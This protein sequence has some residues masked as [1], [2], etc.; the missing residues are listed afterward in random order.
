M[1]GLRDV[2]E[3]D[4]ADISRDIEPG[5][6]ER[7]QQAE[8][9]LV[10]RGEHRGEVPVGK[11]FP[12]GVIAELCRPVSEDRRVG[13][14]IGVI[15][16]VEETLH[17]GLGLDPVLRAGQMDDLAMPQVDQ[18]PGRRLRSRDLVDRQ[19]PRLIPT[20]RVE[21]HQRNR[22]RQF[23]DRIED[24]HLWGDHDETLD[25]L[26]DEVFDVLHDRFVVAGNQVGGAD[27]VAGPAGG[28]L[29]RLQAGR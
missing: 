28:G 24:L 23:L 10:V 16:L 27:Q 2:I 3:A 15:D 17:P 29:D 22:D 5:L 26:V 20:T 19:A 13:A 7:V 12:T 4:H 9:H 6:A 18:V 1:P 11:E 21:R 14:Q 8:R 25:G